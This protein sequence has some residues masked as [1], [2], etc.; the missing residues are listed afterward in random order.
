MTIS[1]SPLRYPGGKSSIALMMREIINASSLRH[2]KY[3][4]P[5]AGG[6]GLALRLLF[7]GV[8]S[9]IHINDLDP[10]IWCFWESVLNRTHDLCKK[11]EDTPVTVS[12]WKIQREI[13]SRGDRDSVVDLG[14]A[15]FF[16]NR[17][18]R[19]GI[20]KSGGI[21]GGSDQQGTYL[22]DCRFNKSELIRRIKRIALHREQIFL[23]NLDAA[24]F[25][26]DFDKKHG[27]HS[28]LCID[29]P[30]Y[31]KGSSLY[32]NYYRKGDHILVA[33][34]IKELSAPWLLTY[35]DATE[36][37]TLYPEFSA[38]RFSINYSAQVK[39]TGLELLIHSQSLIIPEQISEKLSAA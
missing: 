16:L 8:V 17:T 35:D 34:V 39:R 26:V 22:I 7:D 24:E 30:Y 5:Y 1:H 18:N 3:G 32:S 11:I 33:H 23:S 14:F 21:I 31:N 10:A 37:R 36:I 15:A 2:C 6:C 4:E 20:I 25:M 13:L 12:E 28:L 19:S 27:P 29:P 9:E 38:Y